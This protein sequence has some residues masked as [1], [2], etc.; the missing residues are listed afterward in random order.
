[1]I[2][3]APGERVAITVERLEDGDVWP[4]L[5]EELRAGDELE[6]R[7]PAGGRF[8]WDGDR[9]GGPLLLLAGG[10]SRSG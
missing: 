5:T 6:L 8:V 2:A 9:D 3:S 7:D 10:W 4:C 1:L